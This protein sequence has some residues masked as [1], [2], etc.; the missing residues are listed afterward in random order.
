MRKAAGPEGERGMIL[1]NV[2]LFVAIASGIVMLMI[3]AED[4]ALQRATRLSEAAHAQAAANGGELSA[5]VALR[6]DGLVAFDT[7]NSREPWAALAERAAPIKGGS[8]DLAIADA[9]G[10]FNVNLLMKDDPAALQLFGRIGS[11]LGIQPE[12]IA[13]AITH[14]RL[15]GPISDLGPLSGAAALKPE[16]LARLSGL[17]TALPRDRDTKIN[18]NSVSEDLLGIMLD[19]PVAA[20]GLIELRKRRGWLTQADFDA[21]QAPLPPIAGFT[22]DIYWV[23]SRVTI[24][25]TSRQLTSLLVRQRDAQG[26]TVRP[27]ARWRGVAVPAQA[28]PLPF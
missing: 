11:A 1:V 25:D 21:Q 4:G 7:D 5:I 6:R 18:V 17:V 14:I 26:V 16:L 20:H 9:Q 22:S 8:F 13:Q 2:L 23:R 28:P 24:G 19:N 10:R 27:V 12:L 15:S 3:T